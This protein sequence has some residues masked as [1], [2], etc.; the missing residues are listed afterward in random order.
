MAALVAGSSLQG[1]QRVSQLM[2]AAES[3]EKLVENIDGR[4]EKGSC[5]RFLIYEHTSYATSG[6]GFQLSRLLMAALAA[7]MSG[8]MLVVQ[9]DFYTFG[10]P[11]S[12]K[13]WGD[14]T[15]NCVFKTVQ[16]NH[17][18]C[19]VP[20]SSAG[21]R[22]VVG[23]EFPPRYPDDCDPK[24]FRI[25]F[26]DQKVVTIDGGYLEMHLREVSKAARFYS[27]PGGYSGKMTANLCTPTQMPQIKA[28]CRCV[29]RLLHITNPSSY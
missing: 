10:C 7:L 20:K 28:V 16:A 12:A 18:N 19:P 26:G 27:G 4:L 13:D 23:T 9:S 15:K 11:G 6:T 22:C 3:E 1:H 25:T 2:D 5:D 29:S 17:A 24:K 14:E 8:R 21:P